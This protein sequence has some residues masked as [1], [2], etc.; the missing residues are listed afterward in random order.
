MVATKTLVIF[1]TG[2][3]LSRTWPL[4][5][6]EVRTECPGT[7]RCIWTSSNLCTSIEKLCNLL[8]VTLEFYSAE[9]LGFLYRFQSGI[10]VMYKILNGADLRKS[11][12]KPPWGGEKVQLPKCIKMLLLHC[13]V[14]TK[15]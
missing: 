7:Q 1:M 6:W 15:T 12:E 9:A 14:F 13:I 8:A 3:H 2:V 11:E 5:T 4:C 10:N